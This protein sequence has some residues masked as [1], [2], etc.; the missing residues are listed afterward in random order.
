M[1]LQKSGMM[2]SK[3]IE[4][5]HDDKSEEVQRLKSSRLFPVLKIQWLVNVFGEYLAEYFLCCENSSRW[6]LAMIIEKL[7]SMP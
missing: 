7:Q 1:V 4:N 2:D 3:S 6:N 5:S